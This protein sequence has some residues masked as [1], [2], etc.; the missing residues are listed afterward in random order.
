MVNT[1]TQTIAKWSWAR[2]TR[3]AKEPI[4]PEGPTADSQ[5]AQEVIPHPPMPRLSI[6]RWIVRPIPQP[7]A[8]RLGILLA[9]WTLLG[10]VAV[11]LWALVHVWGRVYVLDR[12]LR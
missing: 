11:G 9:G 10:V 4:D 3:L 12:L 8:G 2:K 6:I 7:S 5:T 1:K